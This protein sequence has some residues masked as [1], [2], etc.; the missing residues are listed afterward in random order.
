[1]NNGKI[2]SL[3]CY[4]IKKYGSKVFMVQLSLNLIDQKLFNPQ[5]DNLPG[6]TRISKKKNKHVKHL[7]Q[8]SQSLERYKIT[9]NLQ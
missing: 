4:N 2:V 9:Y 8:L 3:H 7:L 6:N 1:M 5:V